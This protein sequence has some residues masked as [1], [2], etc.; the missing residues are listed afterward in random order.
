MLSTIRISARSFTAC[1]A[2]YLTTRSAR[3]GFVRFNSTNTIT[4]GSA[5]TAYSSTAPTVKYTEDHE[6]IALHEDGVAFI[7]ITKYAADALGDATFID[8]PTAGE[9]VEKGDSIGS[10]ES[11]KSAS[12]IYS[13]VSCEVLEGNKGLEENAGL[14]NQDP[15]GDGWFAKVKVSAQEEIDELM[16]LE[17]YEEFIQ[18]H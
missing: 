3:S 9:S 17:A 10:V 1:R 8:L 15:Q 6:W 4:Q 14:I 13:P 11:V 18:N 5:V 12:E 2:S 7:G 16:N